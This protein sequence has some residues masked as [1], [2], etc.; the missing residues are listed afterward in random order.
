[1]ILV[2]SSEKVLILEPLPLLCSNWR[3]CLTSVSCFSDVT[4]CNFKKI[5]F[6]LSPTS[7]LIVELDQ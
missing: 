7:K 4:V 5:L 6:F 1:M 2:E 3:L